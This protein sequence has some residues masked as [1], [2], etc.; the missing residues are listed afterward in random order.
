[1]GRT[2]LGLSGIAVEEGGDDD[3]HFSCF[4]KALSRA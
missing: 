2:T 4:D 1:M 3:L